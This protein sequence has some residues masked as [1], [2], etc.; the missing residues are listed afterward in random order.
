[1]RKKIPTLERDDQG[2]KVEKE[3][4]INI[5][6]NE[7]DV[8]KCGKA[9]PEDRNAPEDTTT[10][11]INEL[12]PSEIMMRI[13]R[14][15]NNTDL[16]KVV[17]VCR[18]WREV[19]DCSWNW[20]STISIR[21]SRDLEMLTIQRVQHLGELRIQSSCKNEDLNEMFETI[22]SLSKLTSLW[23]HDFDL[24]T[25]DPSLL[26]KTLLAIETVDIS[27]CKLTVEQLNKLF[28][29][30]K[31]TTKLQTL[32]LRGVNLSGVDKD[33]L[34]AGVNQ[35]KSVQLI[36]A[37]LDKWQVRALLTQAATKTNLGCLNIYLNG[38]VGV[39]VDKEMLRLARLNI[40]NLEMW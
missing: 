19:G 36:G 32:S 35:L 30:I 1:M 5:L 21:G 38:G 20:N 23:M 9:E 16:S 24:T 39:T 12:L 28:G 18:R 2:S 3:N 4:D 11:G 6:V 26:V 33:I 8:E 13:F 37:Q 10:T 15:M 34:A 17:A 40:G 29:A 7:G 22:A 31:E 14:M 25:L 27:R